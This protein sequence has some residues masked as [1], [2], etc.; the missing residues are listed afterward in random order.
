MEEEIP[1]PRHSRYR[2][3]NGHGQGRAHGR[4]RDEEDEEEV[5]LDALVEE[6]HRRRGLTG[7]KER[8]ATVEGAG[9]QEVDVDDIEDQEETLPL[10][11]LDTDNVQ[12]H[13]GLWQSPFSRLSQRDTLKGESTAFPLDGNTPGAVTRTATFQPVPLTPAQEKYYNNM[14][15]AYGIVLGMVNPD[16]FGRYDVLST[17][18]SLPLYMVTGREEYFVDSPFRPALPRDAL[19]LDASGLK[20]R[21]QK[22]IAAEDMSGASQHSVASTLRSTPSPT[23]TQSRRIFPRGRFKGKDKAYRLSL[24]AKSGDRNDSSGRNCPDTESLDYSKGVPWQSKNSIRT[25]AIAL[26]LCLMTGTEPPDVFR[27]PPCASLEAWVDVQTLPAEKAGDIVGERLLQQYN[28]LQ[29]RANIQVSLD[30]TF[31]DMSK[32]LEALRKRADQKRMLLH[33]N[34]HGVPR[35]TADGEIWVFNPSYTQYVPVRPEEWILTLGIPSILVVDANGAGNVIPAFAKAHAALDKYGDVSQLASKEFHNALENT[36]LEN[37][38]FRKFLVFA[39]CGKHETLPTNAGLPADLFT[40]CMTTPVQTALRVYVHQYPWILPPS[41]VDVVNHIPGKVSDRSTPLGQINWV[42]TAVTDAVAWDILPYRAFIKL[43]REDLLLGTLSRNFLLACRLMR[44]YN[45]HPQM[46]PPLPATLTDHAMWQTWDLFLERVLARLPAIFAHCKM[47]TPE[48]AAKLGLISPE[49][50][51]TTISDFNN[52]DAIPVKKTNEKLKGQST[53]SLMQASLERER[54]LMSLLRDRLTSQYTKGHTAID[55]LYVPSANTK[56]SE[57]TN[58]VNFFDE[59]LAN[60]EAWIKR[61]RLQYVGDCSSNNLDTLKQSCYSGEFSSRGGYSVYLP[62]ILQVM[63][64]N[65]YRKQ[66]LQLLAQFCSLGRWAVNAVFAVGIY[67]YVTRAIKQYVEGS[68]SPGSKPNDKS[69]PALVGICSEFVAAR[70]ECGDDLVNHMLIQCLSKFLYS[71]LHSNLSGTPSDSDPYQEI[72]PDKFVAVCFTLCQLM[73]RYKEEAKS[74]EN[75]QDSKINSNAQKII[76]DEKIPLL[77][78]KLL[79]VWAS[80]HTGG[81]SSRPRLERSNEPAPTKAVVWALLTVGRSCLGFSPGLSLCWSASAPDTILPFL[82]HPETQIRATTLETLTTFLRRDH[83]ETSVGGSQPV[84]P[85]GHVSSEVLAAA[86]SGFGKDVANQSIRGMLSLI[87]NQQRKYLAKYPV[88]PGGARTSDK[89]SASETSGL[90]LY[91]SLGMHLGLVMSGTHESP[92]VTYRR[93]HRNDIQI[94]VPSEDLNKDSI[95]NAIT[96]SRGNNSEESPV[97]GISSSP[98]GS[99]EIQGASDLTCAVPPADY[100]ASVLTSAARENSVN[101]DEKSSHDDNSQK[102]RGGIRSFAQAFLSNKGRR[103]SPD[104][105]PK[106]ANAFSPLDSEPCNVDQSS[107]ASVKQDDIGQDSK[108]GKTGTSFGVNSSSFARNE[109]QSSGG[110]S[111]PGLNLALSLLPSISS[112]QSSDIPA[113][114]LAVAVCILSLASDL[115]SMVRIEAILG[116]GWF[117]FS[118][119]HELA[120]LIVLAQHHAEAIR[121]HQ[122]GKNSEDGSSPGHTDPRRAAE[123]ASP[124]GELYNRLDDL[125]ER[126]RLQYLRNSGL[127]EETRKKERSNKDDFGDDSL[128][129]RVYELLGARGILYLSIW[130]VLLTL[131]QDPCYGVAQS[132]FAIIQKLYGKLIC[133]LRAQSIYSQRT[134]VILRDFEQATDALGDVDIFS[135][136]SSAP[137]RTDDSLSELLPSE[138]LHQDILDKPAETAFDRWL[139]TPAAFGD[140]CLQDLRLVS[141]LYEW[142]IQQFRQRARPSDGMSARENCSASAL[143]A[144]HHRSDVWPL[145]VSFCKEACCLSAACLSDSWFRY[146]REAASVY[147]SGMHRSSSRSVLERLATYTLGELSWFDK[148]D[149]ALEL[150]KNLFHR[151]IGSIGSERISLRSFDGIDDTN[152][153]DLNFSESFVTMQGKYDPF[154]NTKRPLDKEVGP[155][156]YSHRGYSQNTRSNLPSEYHLLHELVSNE[157]PSRDSTPRLPVSMLSAMTEQ[158]VKDVRNWDVKPTQR[159]IIDV[160]PSNM[161]ATLLFHPYK[162]Y[163]V[164]GDDSDTLIIHDYEAGKSSN[165]VH[166]SFDLS[167]IS[168]SVRQLQCEHRIGGVDSQLKQGELG[169]AREANWQTRMSKYVDKVRKECVHPESGLVENDENADRSNRSASNVGVSKTSAP[170]GT[171]GA[172]LP[173]RRKS[174]ASNS[175]LATSRPKHPRVTAL[176]W[177]NEHSDPLLLCGSEDGCIRVWRNLFDEN[178]RDERTANHPSFYPYQQTP[179]TNASSGNASSGEET[180]AHAVES[181]VAL[182]DMHY[183]F[184]RVKNTAQEGKARGSGLVTSWMPCNGSVAVAGN[185]PFVRLWDVDRAQCIG[186]MPSGSDS[187]ITSLTTAWPG[188]GVLLSG[189]GNGTLTLLDT[190]EPGKRPSWSCN[191]VER[192]PK[193]LKEHKR[194]IVRVCQPRCGTGYAIVSGAVSGEVKFWDLRKGPTQSCV[195]T[196]QAHNH[197]MTAMALHD[198]APILATGSHSQ[199]VKLW[200]T[201][202]NGVPADGSSAERV[203][204]PEGNIGDNVQPSLRHIIRFHDGFLGQRIGPVSHLEFHP[205]EMLLGIGTVDNIVSLHVNKFDGEQKG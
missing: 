144:L 163:V 66:A 124:S 203:I 78:L 26:V 169:L 117:I 177:I 127:L 155:R 168:Q 191:S 76:V 41:A 125:T 5:D 97:T 133:K 31:G 45:C 189:C 186:L 162:P 69:L 199:N 165:R 72:E 95:S 38:D 62:I 53:G 47:L 154:G 9:G 48:I 113:R 106:S 120:M 134:S 67:P 6:Q 8:T 183:R 1:V 90:H 23:P 32:L 103:E 7:S 98:T 91:I 131:Q 61:A 84:D 80:I 111:S 178:T 34:G 161:A 82:S 15:R 122:P 137:L 55:T 198:Y 141:R 107:K 30:P 50:T 94:N 93:F 187:C 128:M 86:K 57:S 174:S 46:Y 64:S 17:L 59:Q 143:R 37:F 148:A 39:S 172:Q 100:L 35:P 136:K 112:R 194:W 201:N 74:E 44:K 22:I 126:F 195:R 119:P 164:I 49:L 193:R 142:Q 2:Q 160:K 130:R 96:Y 73:H 179:R 147:V 87:Q 109:Q 14:E 116:V 85:W 13:E 10:P 140:A 138:F 115:S 159:C 146:I 149:S 151:S 79:S 28:A 70:P 158:K 42:L 51:S 83:R 29:S 81:S 108:R 118:Y 4:F 65:S 175:S 21:L 173:S 56:A 54:Q 99:K 204:S 170:S 180:Y 58:R 129:Q 190:R 166:N 104:A 181:F 3:G 88:N 202:P 75:T 52:K 43:F 145:I 156:N 139:L 123:H 196:L 105:K 182:P 132:S 11:P 205:Y 71:S 188:S 18:E 63:L 16:S 185:S 101:S 197:P 152:P 77:L 25:S 192:L 157:P 200:Y 68:S 33:L 92:I 150:R 110:K 60:F 184:K 176:Q 12:H 24:S 19:F 20:T 171:S 121:N 153:S 36:R 89:D 40:S 167:S 27:V 114:E 102:N 135:E